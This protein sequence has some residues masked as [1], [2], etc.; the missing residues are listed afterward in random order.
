MPGTRSRGA[1]CCS[2]AGACL[3][4]HTLHAPAGPACRRG[5]DTAAPTCLAPGAPEAH[6]GVVRAAEQRLAVLAEAHGVHAPP[7]AVQD[8]VLADAPHQLLLSEHFL[9]EGARRDLANA[10]GAQ[11]AQEGHHRRSGKT[12][13][14]ATAGSARPGDLQITVCA[15]L[16]GP[17]TSDTPLRSSVSHPE[18]WQ[19]GFAAGRAPC[20]AAAAGTAVARLM[21]ALHAGDAPTQRRPHDVIFW[22][23]PLLSPRAGVAPVPRCSSRFLL[24]PDILRHAG[25]PELGLLGLCDSAHEALHNSLVPALGLADLGALLCAAHHPRS[26]A[27]VC[28]QL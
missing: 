25:M 4:T 12:V 27:A 17:R 16:R 13:Y 14:Q 11:G 21:L 24:L 20:R 8:A 5:W 19:S 28:R 9:P 1:P 10:P 7:V 6:V 26:A 2:A 23:A 15:R 18:A 3:H 22:R